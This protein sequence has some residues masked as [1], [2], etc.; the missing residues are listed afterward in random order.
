MQVRYDEDIQTFIEEAKAVEQE[1]ETVEIL[2]WDRSHQHSAKIIRDAISGQPLDA[3][4]VS[5]AM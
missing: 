2:A 5:V 3:S 1:S 4:M